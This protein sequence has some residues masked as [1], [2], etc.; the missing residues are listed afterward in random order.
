MTTRKLKKV[1]DERVRTDYPKPTTYTAKYSCANC[2]WNG[3][4]C[5]QK[6]IIAPPM[7]MC[8]TCEC[9]GAKKSLPYVRRDPVPIPILKDPIIPTSVP[10]IPPWPRE[11]PRPFPPKPYLDWPQRQTTGIDNDIDRGDTICIDEPREGLELMPK[12]RENFKAH[13]CGDE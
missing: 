3:S 1:S 7:A 4:I 2:G 10:D 8:P 11:L 5:F 12:T 6:G 9:Y 13:G